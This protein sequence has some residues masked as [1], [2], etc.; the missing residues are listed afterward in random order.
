[1]KMYV[2][3]YGHFHLQCNEFLYSISSYLILCILLT[4]SLSEE[5]PQKNRVS[6]LIIT[7]C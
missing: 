1:M 7:K 5:K 6:R 3:M 2:A 4:A